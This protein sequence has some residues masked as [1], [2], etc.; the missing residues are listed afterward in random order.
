MRQYLHEYGSSELK[1]VCLH[2]M[3]SLSP[4]PP[5]NWVCFKVYAKLRSA[6]QFSNLIFE[7]PMA[8]ASTV[9]AHFIKCIEKHVEQQRGSNAQT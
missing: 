3:V 4:N 1:C 2:N 7:K 8:V 5:Q 6:N 9:T